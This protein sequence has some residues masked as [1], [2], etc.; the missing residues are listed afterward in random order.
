MN[1]NVALSEA[2]AQAVIAA[3]A[4][5]LASRVAALEAAVESYKALDEWLAK[6][7]FPPASWIWAR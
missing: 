7:G 4:T 1:P 6:G 3:E 5:S 2:R